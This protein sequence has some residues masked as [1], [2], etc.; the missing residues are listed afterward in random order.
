MYFLT[1][2]VVLLIATG[3][4][5]SQSNGTVSMG[6]IQFYGSL[7]PLRWVKNAAGTEQTT[8][9]LNAT[10]GQ[11]VSGGQNSYARVKNDTG[12]SVTVNVSATLNFSVA[13]TTHSNYG[14]TSSSSLSL[15]TLTAMG[16][17][18]NPFGSY[19][20]AAPANKTLSFGTGT[21]ANG[22]SF[23]FSGTWS[24][25]LYGGSDQY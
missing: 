17:A 23:A 18:T 24:I 22:A 5:L 14:S 21:L 4:A 2:M 7:T 8:I 15:G 16:M 1:T 25:S 9:T 13:G 6:S 10:T 20:L 12:S 3:P 11:S 19:G